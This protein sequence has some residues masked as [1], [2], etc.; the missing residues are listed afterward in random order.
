MCRGHDSPSGR[1]L[2]PGPV[3]LDHVRGVNRGLEPDDLEHVG[4]GRDSR[5]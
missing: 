5:A 1:S 4:A 3:D 2:L